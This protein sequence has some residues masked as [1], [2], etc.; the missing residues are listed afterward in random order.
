MEIGF[1]EWKTD[2]E[3]AEKGSWIVFYGAN[4]RFKEVSNRAEQSIAFIGSVDI[5]QML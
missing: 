1:Y 2:R 5:F 3:D 4:N